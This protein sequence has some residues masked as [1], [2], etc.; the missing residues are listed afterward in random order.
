MTRARAGEERM[1]NAL[2]ADYYAQRASSGP[3]LTE[4]AVVSAQEGCADFPA[5]RP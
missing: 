3:I 4:A 1:L 5:Y 2:M